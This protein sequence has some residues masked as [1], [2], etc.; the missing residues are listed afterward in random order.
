[1]GKTSELLSAK[2]LVENGFKLVTK[3]PF[4][5]MHMKYYARNSVMLFMNT[6]VTRWDKHDFLVG[7]GEMRCGEYYA[8]TFRW[9]TKRVDLVKIYE[10]VTGTQF[11]Q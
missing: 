2:F 6:P 1:M 10:S 5:N 7:Y 4:E 8:V 3:S 9:I 11:E